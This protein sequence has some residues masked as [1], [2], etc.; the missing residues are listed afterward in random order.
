M[1]PGSEALSLMVKFQVCE[2]CETDVAHQRNIP[3]YLPTFFIFISRYNI[4]L[5]E[6][7]PCES[8]WWFL[9]VFVIRKNFVATRHTMAY[10]PC[11]FGLPPQESPKSTSSRE[12][13]NGPGSLGE[14]LSL[15][16]LGAGWAAMN[17][18]DRLWEYHGDIMDIIIIYIY[19]IMMICYLGLV[20]WL[21]IS[22][23]ISQICSTFGIWWGHITNG[24]I[25]FYPAEK[26][27]D[28]TNH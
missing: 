27:W 28:K 17:F 22:W 10:P 24:F 5:L 20:S 14:V 6:I 25:M 13:R 15:G 2:T 18:V 23:V 19:D 3:N 1:G 16:A 9:Y 7:P 11:R 8:P 26:F 4:R 12:T 21:V